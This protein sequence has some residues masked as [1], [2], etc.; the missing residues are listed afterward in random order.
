MNE[1]DGHSDASVTH[2]NLASVAPAA[3][4]A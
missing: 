3:A 4:A 1:P 2:N